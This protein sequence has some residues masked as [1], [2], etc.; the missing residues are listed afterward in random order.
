MIE[1]ITQGL[2]HIHSWHRENLVL[3]SILVLPCPAGRSAIGLAETA[4]MLTTAHNRREVRRRR[5]YFTFRTN[6]AV[7]IIFAMAFHLPVRPQTAHIPTFGAQSSVLAL[8]YQ[9]FRLRPP[10]EVAPTHQIAVRYPRAADMI[11]LHTALMA[12]NLISDGESSR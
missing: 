4:D 7:R 1:G 10:H 3:A 6:S 5:R 8:V 9:R 11:S 2:L 12:E